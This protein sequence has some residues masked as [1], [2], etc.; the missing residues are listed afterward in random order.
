MRSGPRLKLIDGR[1]GFGA[2]RSRSE[3]LPSKDC[4]RLLRGLPAFRRTQHCG[5]KRIIGPKLFA[6]AVEAYVEH[7]RSF[8]PKEAYYLA[9]H[10][11]HLMF[12]RPDER[13]FI[14]AEMIRQTSFIGT[15]AVTGVDGKMTAT[16]VHV[17]DESARGTGEG[18]R[19]FDLG[20]NSTMTNANVDSGTE[21]DVA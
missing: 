10:R 13:P 6:A 1:S 9:N 17:F 7:A 19:S 2:N 20:P 12:V 18:H 3:K 21:A 5:A 14:T 16:E 11:G 8:E 15:A 4:C